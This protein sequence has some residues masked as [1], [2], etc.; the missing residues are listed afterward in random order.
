MSKRTQIIVFDVNETLLDIEV[1]NPFFYRTFGEAR[2]M[3]EWFAELIL[4]S[5]ALTLIGF[6]ND[7]SKLAIEVLFMFAKARSIKLEENDVVEFVNIMC[8]L[9]AHN[10]VFQALNM[11]RD[12]DFRIVTLTNSPS[13]S[14]KLLLD[15]ANLSGYFEKQFSVDSVK[16]F[17]PSPDT[18]KMVATNLGVAINKLRLVSAH[19]WDTTG[20]TAA[21]CRSALVARHYNAPLNIGTQ[22]DI[23]DLDLICVARKIIETDI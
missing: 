5:Q 1:L 18:Y 11:L 17:K 13:E 21:G 12:A 3:R 19:T 23:V 16:K 22:P 4:Y 6:Y 8:K 15:K 9:P 7:F 10:D 2:I 20:A 14:S